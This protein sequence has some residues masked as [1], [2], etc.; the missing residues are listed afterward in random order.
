MD[1]IWTLG[2]VEA[3]ITDKVEENLKLDYKAAD[4]LK[5]ND[6]NNK[7][8]TKDVSAMANSAGGIIIYGIKE[9]IS[10]KHLPE[11]IDPVKRADC[12]KERLDQ[13][14][15]NIQPKIDGVIIS[16]VKFNDDVVYVVEIPQST[17]AHQAQDFRYYKRYNFESLPMNDYEVRD[18]MNRLVK[19]DLTVE[20]YLLN[21]GTCYSLY[22]NIINKGVV[23]VNHYK[24]ICFIPA[25]EERLNSSSV[26][27][28]KESRESGNILYPE[29]NKHEEIS[30][31][32]FDEYQKL[33]VAEGVAKIMWKIYADDMLPKQ[34]EINLADLKITQ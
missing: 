17:T 18:V 6:K 8:I 2:R 29:D 34:G 9:N 1:N 15:K 19:P 3:Y 27:R 33:I 22:A 14:I 23:F 21:R 32:N 4:A 20:F 16:P 30:L 25:Q 12:S 28:Y 5:N 26:I 11:K 13:I 24:L 10:D 7:E 31:Y